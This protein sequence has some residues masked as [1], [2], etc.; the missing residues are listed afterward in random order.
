MDLHGRNTVGQEVSYHVFSSDLSDAAQF[1][2]YT[3][4]V[5]R[6]GLL[7]A[8]AEAGGGEAVSGVVRG[9]RPGGPECSGGAQPA[10][11]GPHC[12]KVLRPDRGS[13]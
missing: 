5:R 1:I 7:P 11:G 2:F 4:A 10:A 3:A 8:S 12:E 6:R 13:G 9:G